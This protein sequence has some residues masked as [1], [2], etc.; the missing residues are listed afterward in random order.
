MGRMARVWVLRAHTLAWIIPY[1]IQLLCFHNSPNPQASR[2]LLWRWLHCFL[3]Q[4]QRWW[5]WNW[6]PYRPCIKYWGLANSVPKSTITFFTPQFA[7]SNTNPQVILNNSLLTFERTPHIPAVTFDPHFKFSAHVKSIVTQASTRMN[8]LKA[9][10]GTNW[11]QLLEIVIY[12]Y[13]NVFS[14]G[15]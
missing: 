1:P 4:L 15:I 12:M 2:Q 6:S 5:S 9:L 13:T 7:Q 11:N 14:A 10:A 8:I 3:F